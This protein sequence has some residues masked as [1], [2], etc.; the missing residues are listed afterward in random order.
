VPI[1]FRLHPQEMTYI[2][3]QSDAKVLIAGEDFL[4]TVKESGRTCPR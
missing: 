4:E 2:I 3:N 1:N